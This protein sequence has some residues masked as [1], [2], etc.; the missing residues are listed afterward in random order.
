MKDFKP[1]PFGRLDLPSGRG[2]L[3]LTA[4]SVPGNSVMDVRLILLTLIQ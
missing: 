2:L 3:T 1:L 4:L